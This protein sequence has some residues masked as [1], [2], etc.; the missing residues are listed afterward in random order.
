L[1][2]LGSVGAG[3]L[4][5]RQPRLDP[6]LRAMLQSVAGGGVGVCAW[7]L[8]GPSHGAGAALLAGGSV[9]ALGTGV[10][11]GRWARW[12]SAY[13][14]ARNAADERALQE[15]SRRLAD[16]STDPAGTP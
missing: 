5:R 12:R 8:I 7:M 2:V 11:M 13:R 6:F 1:G 14:A 9:L 15:L 4:L 3:W 16:G 10:L